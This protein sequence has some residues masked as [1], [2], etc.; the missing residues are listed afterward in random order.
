MLTLKA[1]H[2][3][4]IKHFKQFK[5]FNFIDKYLIFVLELKVWY[6]LV[7]SSIFEAELWRLQ[8]TD[9]LIQSCW[10]SNLAIMLV[11]HLWSTHR[12]KC[13]FHLLDNWNKYSIFI[14]HCISLKQR[15]PCYYSM[16]HVTL[17]SATTVYRLP[18][19]ANYY[20]PTSSLWLHSPLFNSPGLRCLASTAALY[21]FC[22]Y[23][24]LCILVFSL[25]LHW[26]F[27]FAAPRC[28]FSA[29]RPGGVNLLMISNGSLQGYQFCSTWYPPSPLLL[30]GFA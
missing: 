21:S 12:V 10:N 18:K 23:L 14:S 9:V 4:T 30:C 20:G 16:N 13:S 6:S 5:Q 17:T 11:F 19:R 7:G 8:G 29:C 26:L 22:F 1:A 3:E 24:A 15:N 2:K 27:H 28:N 25:L